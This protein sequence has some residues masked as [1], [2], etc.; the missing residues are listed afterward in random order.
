MKITRALII[1]LLFSFESIITPFTTE[2]N[3]WFK[4]DPLHIMIHDGGW[5]A[6]KNFTWERGSSAEKVSPKNLHL[7][8][9]RT[10]EKDQ[11]QI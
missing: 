5:V 8:V 4:I 11:F 1:N 3:A 9:W 7:E 2:E 10:T 6:D